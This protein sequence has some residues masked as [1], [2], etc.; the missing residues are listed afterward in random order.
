VETKLK[1]RREEEERTKRGRREDEER[2]KRGHRA[3][4]VEERTKRWSPKEA[5]LLEK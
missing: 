4:E 3:D 5:R 1:R 2:T